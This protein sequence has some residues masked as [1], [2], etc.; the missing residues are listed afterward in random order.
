[1]Q[2][3]ITYLR[4]TLFVGILGIFNLVFL[5]FS[6][7]SPDFTSYAA[8]VHRFTSP[9]F[10]WSFVGVAIVGL[11]F[12]AVTSGKPIE[13]SKHDYNGIHGTTPEFV[14]MFSLAILAGALLAICI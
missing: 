9:I 8:N 2:V 4:S 6:K 5:H 10:L 7:K 14:Y 3:R 1:M 12:V 11:I 13:R